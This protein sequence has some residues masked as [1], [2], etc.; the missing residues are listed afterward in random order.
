MGENVGHGFQSFGL[1]AGIKTS[2]RLQTL[3]EFVVSS[4]CF[5]VSYKYT[6]S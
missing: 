6:Q 5:V 3:W 4:H 1:D 2:L